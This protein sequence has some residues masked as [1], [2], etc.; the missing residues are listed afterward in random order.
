VTGTAKKGGRFDDV[1]RKVGRAVADLDKEAERL[2]AY[3]NE[4]VV[5]AVRKHSSQALRTAAK[6]L[7][8]AADYMERTQ[9]K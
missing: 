6:E 5:P 3:L 8:R 9:K 2:V 7:A 1:G 4:E